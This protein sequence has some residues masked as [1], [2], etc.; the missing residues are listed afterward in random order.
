MTKYDKNR[1]GYSR[2][3]EKGWDKIM[4]VKDKVTIT[5]RSSTHYGRVGEIKDVSFKDNAKGLYI[6]E[7]AGLRLKF[8]GDDIEKVRE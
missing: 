3:F 6:V 4:R 1:V 8:T 7:I 2:A 5:L